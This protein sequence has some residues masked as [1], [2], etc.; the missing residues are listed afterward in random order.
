MIGGGVAMGIGGVILDVGALAG[1]FVFL[2][3]VFAVATILVTRLKE[4][5]W[6]VKTK[7]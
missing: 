5:G 4:T 3:S 6:R 2:A 7:E 1:Y